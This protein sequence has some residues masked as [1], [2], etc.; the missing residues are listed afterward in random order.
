MF[1]IVQN[2]HE[3]NQD[4]GNLSAIYSQMVNGWKIL[5]SRSETFLQSK[6]KLNTSKQINIQEKIKN[7]GKLCLHGEIIVNQCLKPQYHQKIMNSS[8]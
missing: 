8:Y 1:W 4:N 6:K 2:T 5:G 7:N 3:N